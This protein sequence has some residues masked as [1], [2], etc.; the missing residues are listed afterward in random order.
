[1]VV[2][3]REAC[4]LVAEELSKL[5]GEYEFAVIMSRSKKDSA[6][7]QGS[8]DLRRWYPAAQWERAYGGRPYV[9]DGQVDEQETGE[10]FTV[11][12]DRAAIKDFIARFKK[13]TTLLLS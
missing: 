8:V 7:R 4:A 11:G 13:R 5:L 9:D 1:M 10:D 6:P 3:D 12:S 2:V